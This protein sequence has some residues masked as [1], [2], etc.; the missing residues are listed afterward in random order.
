MQVIIRNINWST[1][2]YIQ[3]FWL[4]FKPSLAIMERF[5]MSL[6][7]MI[8]CTCTLYWQLWQLRIIIIK[9]HMI[10]AI[11]GLINIMQLHHSINLFV[12]L[13]QFTFLRYRGIV[14]PN[15]SVRLGPFTQT[16]FVIIYIFVPF[17]V[18]SIPVSCFSCQM[19]ILWNIF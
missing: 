14:C 16:L 10:W 9:D 18:R 5:F 19:C 1:Q 2:V 3:A 7:L 17:L 11:I 15:L 6:E 8:T 13:C 12:K 4:K